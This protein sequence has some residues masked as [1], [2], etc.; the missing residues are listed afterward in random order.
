[1]PGRHTSPLDQKTPFIAD[2]LR[3]TLS[4]TAVGARYGVRRQ[5]GSQ[6]LERSLTS[7][8]PALA[9]RAR[10]PCSRPQQTPQHVVAALIAGRGR[11]PSWGAKT[12]GSLLHTRHPNGSLPG[13][14]TVCDIWRRHGLVA[15]TRHR[16]HLGPPG[17]PT[18]LIAAPHEGWRA[19]FNGPVNTADGLYG[20]PVTVAE[21]YRRVRLG[22]QALASTRVAEA[23][24]VGHPPLQRVRVAHAP[25]HRQRGA[26][27]PPYPGPALTTLRLVGTPGELPRVQRARQAPATWPPGA[28]ASSAAG[29]NPP[30]HATPPHPVRGPTDGPRL[31]TPP[32]SRCATSVPPGASGGTITGAMFHTP[33]V[34]KMSASRTS[35][36]ASGRSPA[37]RSNSA[38]GSHDTCASQMPRGSTHT[39]AVTVTH[40]SRT[41]L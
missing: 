25:P 28:Q 38:G 31:T 12:L 18:T 14:S 17:Q 23:Q 24:P 22:W 26:L 19:E 11:H 36:R 29:R 20:S 8:P 16:R 9:A 34:A 4:S 6:W 37:D 1:M 2:D 39:T 13:R 3:K 33:A 21:G 15:Q 30:P 40:V 10:Q 7:G 35:P 5:T 32:V 27:G 41:T